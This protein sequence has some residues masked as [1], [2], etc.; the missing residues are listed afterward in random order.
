[1]AFRTELLPTLST[2]K[3]KLQ[4][5]SVKQVPTK[6]KVR[7]LSWQDS[8]GHRYLQDPISKPLLGPRKK[9]QFLTI[10]SNYYVR[11]VCTREAFH[12]IGQRCSLLHNGNV[13]VVQNRRAHTVGSKP[14]QEQYSTASTGENL[15]SEHPGLD[16]VHIRDSCQCNQCVDPSTKQKLFETTDIPADIT[17]RTVD[18]IN[19]ELWIRW[20]NDVSSYSTNHQT[21]VK[22]FEDRSVDTGMPPRITWDAATFHG[23]TQ[24]FDWSD[25]QNDVVA[26]AEMLRAL[27]QYGLVFLK[28]IPV[29]SGLDTAGGINSIGNALGPFRDSLYGPTWDVKSVPDAKNIAYTHQKL[30]LHMDL[31]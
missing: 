23:S 22:S 15:L 7:G 8:P 24:W 11:N 26:L 16:Y 17:P 12:K 3:S 27:H 10:H 1:M 20:K 29:G 9:R 14:E 30:C 25:C 4:G 5:A 28:S 18:S 13:P 21:K 2:S 19:G 6:C 31:L